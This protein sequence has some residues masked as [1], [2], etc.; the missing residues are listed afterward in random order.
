MLLRNNISLTDTN[1]LKGIALILL[2]IH[3]LFW[4]GKMPVDDVEILGYTVVQNVG[5]WSRVCVSLFVILSGYGLTVSAPKFNERGSLWQFYKKRYIKLMLNY[6]FIYLMFVP[7]GVF[8]VGRTFGEVYHGSWI[9]PILD[10]FG[11]HSA[12]TRDAFGYNPTWWF[13]GC[14]IMLY[15]IFPLLYRYRHNWWV[16]ILFS[17][18]SMEFGGY[19]PLYHE[20]ALYVPSF[21]AGILL[22]NADVKCIQ[23]KWWQKILLLLF[24]LIVSLLRFKIEGYKELWDMLIALSIIITYKTMGVS[25]IIEQ[26]LAFI[27]KHSFNIF[28][29]HT[30][31]FWLYF[32]PFIYWT[33]NPVLI[34]LT[35]ISTCLVISVLLEYIK[36]KT[37]YYRLQK[38][39]IDYDT[40]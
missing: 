10:F 14:I 24:L 2:L 25:A 28:L 38:Y 6:W 3:H 39:L 30:F 23:T 40:I 32:R 8:V 4:T 27:G 18:L 11:L 22:A 13:Y 36:G 17:L 1:A 5:I 15:A 29:F 34:F 31:I 16:L 26:A 35:L 12:V 7:Y 37:G 21:V 19:I 33:T 9:R 20:C